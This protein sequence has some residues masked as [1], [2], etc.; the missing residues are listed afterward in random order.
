MNTEQ[1]R[2]VSLIVQQFK[3][4]FPMRCSCCGREFGTAKDFLLGRPSSSVAEGH[5]CVSWPGMTSRTRRRTV[6]VLGESTVVSLGADSA[7]LLGVFMNP[8]VG[9]EAGGAEGQTRGLHV[10]LDDLPPWIVRGAEVQARGRTYVVTDMIADGGGMLQLV[11]K[12]R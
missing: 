8:A 9:A 11:L 7:D 5:R 2:V 6:R 10:M 12:R 3:S 1:E 4:H